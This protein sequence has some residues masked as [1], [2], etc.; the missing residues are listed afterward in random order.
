MTD[1]RAVRF[2]AAAATL[3]AAH[4]VGDFM[5]STDTQAERKPCQSDR[6]V[7]CSEAESWRALAGHVASYHA[8][9]VAALVA[10][11]RALGLRLSPRRVAAGVALSAVTHAVIDRRWPVRLWLDHTGSTG[12]KKHGG[13]MHVDQAMH[14]VCLWAAA[15]VIAGGPR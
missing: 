14:H 13:A 15:L 2:A 5:A 12:F 4:H 6:A 1:N 9:Q 7:E 10:A 8:V 11:D 3:A